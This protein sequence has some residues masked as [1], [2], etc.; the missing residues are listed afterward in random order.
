MKLRALA[1]AIGK[2]QAE[3]VATACCIGR[4]R[5]VRNGTVNEPPPMPKIAEA[6][7]ITLPAAVN[8][9]LPGML[10][11]ALGLR[12]RAICAA[13]T[14][15][16]T[17]MIFCSIGPWIAEA[18]L[19]PIPAP[20]RIPRVIQTKIGHCTAP[21]RWCSRMA[22][23]E[24]KTMVASDVPTARWVSTEASKP[25]KVKLNTSTG[26]M[27]MPPPTPNSPASTPAQAPSSK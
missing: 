25:C 12:S 17:P 11:L 27:M 14:R 6:Q 2:P 15:A 7:P 10:R 26:T 5:Q 13:I 8:P 16:N 3:D 1:T 24:V 22:L 9:G 18:V 20:T 21:L 19:A 23:I 4:L